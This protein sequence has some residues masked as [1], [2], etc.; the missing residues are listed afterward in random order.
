MLEIVINQLFTG[1][2]QLKF[3]PGK[4]LINHF[5]INNKW[6]QLTSRAIAKDL[7]KKQMRILLQI[8]LPKEKYNI[9]ICL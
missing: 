6:Y 9:N 7:K 1:S 2:K 3:T 4:T 8:I 5:L